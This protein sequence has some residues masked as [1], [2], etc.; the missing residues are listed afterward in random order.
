MSRTASSFWDRVERGERCWEWTGAK[1]RHGA[2]V[3][4]WEGKTRRAAAV[5]FALTKDRWPWATVKTSC[6]NPACCHPD[7]LVEAKAAGPPKKRAAK[8]TLRPGVVLPRPAYGRGSVRMLDPGVWELRLPVRAAVWPSPPAVSRLF[9][10]SRGEAEEALAELREQ[11]EHGG[12]LR[13]DP[14]L[15]ELLDAYLSWYQRES[16]EGVRGADQVVAAAR[17]LAKEASALDDVRVGALADGRAINEWELAM[18]DAGRPL[19]EV[20]VLHQELVSLLGWGVAHGWIR[21]ARDPRP[22]LAS[23][24]AR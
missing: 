13:V 24:G 9:Q 1:D 22:L 3:V 19:S 11:A 5:A 7:H 15:G 4:W 18:V 6:G 14:T 17:G 20:R 8:R 16:D 21:R 23:L 10:G 12:P 2:G